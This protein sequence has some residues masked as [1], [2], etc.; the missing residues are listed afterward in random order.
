MKTAVVLGEHLKDSKT[1][2]AGKRWAAGLLCFHRALKDV[3]LLVSWALQ[4][5]ELFPAQHFITRHESKKREVSDIL[6]LFC[7][8]NWSGVMLAVDFSCS[9]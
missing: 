3:A 5:V 4:E 2:K 8:I 9:V 6:V 7:L 1:R